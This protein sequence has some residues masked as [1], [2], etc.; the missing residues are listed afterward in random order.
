MNLTPKIKTL[1]NKLKYINV[2]IPH[3]QSATVLLAVRVGS[4]YENPNTAGLSHFIEHIVFKGTKKYPT[5][6]SLASTVDGIGAEFNAFTSKEYTGFYVKSASNHLNLAIDVLAQLV[7]HPLIRKKDIQK[8]KGVILEEINMRE[9]TPMMKVNEE[10]ERLLYGSSPLGREII[11]SKKTVSNM[12]KKDFISYRKKFYQPQN[13]VLAVVGGV[14][15]SPVVAKFISRNTYK[16]G[17]FSRTRSRSGIKD[18]GAKEL[19]FSQSK[20]RVRLKY[21]KTEQAHLCLGVRAFKR[22]SKYRYPMAVLSTILGGNMSSRLFTEVRE[23]RGLAYYIKSDINTY[24]DNGYLVVQA[25]VDKN[26]VGEAVKVILGEL[27]RVSR[28]SPL[29][30]GSAGQ[31]K[32]LKKAKD[33]LKGKLALGLESSQQVASLYTKDLLLERKIRKPKDIIKGIEKVTVNDIQKIA[34]KIFQ[35]KNLN[36]ALIGP[37]KNKQKFAKIL[38]M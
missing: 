2:N 38:K 3:M 19:K 8:E 28:V 26:K 35:N 4:R 1:K 14:K 37:Y 9:D 20:P 7:W 31:A 21:K 10:F 18:P 29:R 15:K 16:P 13:M 17:A 33:Y 12:Q 32:E 36:L 30:Q 5:A 24:F 25:G 27:I 6:L 34:Q 22:G 11:G 23:K